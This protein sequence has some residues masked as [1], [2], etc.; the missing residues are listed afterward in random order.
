LKYLA[1]QLSTNHHAKR[2]PFGLG[3]LGNSLRRRSPKG[4]VIDPANLQML[5]PDGRLW[6]YSRSDAQ[7]FPAG[8]TYDARTDHMAFGGGRSFP[9]GT[10]FIFMGA[11]IGKYTFGFADGSD[12]SSPRGLCTIV[13]E[14]RAVRYVDAEE[15]FADLSHTLHTRQ[16]NRVLTAGAGVAHADGGRGDSSPSRSA[17]SPSSGSGSAGPEDLAPVSLRRGNIPQ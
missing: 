6:T 2:V 4:Y 13:S 5:L 9:C 7:R 16:H 11:V 12:E 3:R 14:G 17:D 8:R 1:D 10:E 15:A